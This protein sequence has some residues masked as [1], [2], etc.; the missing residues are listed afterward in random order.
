M[1]TELEDLARR[2]M[3]CKKWRWMGGMRLC[4]P[5][6]YDESAPWGMRIG[7][8]QG[9]VSNPKA[10]PDLSDPATVGCLLALVREAWP[11]DRAA[12]SPMQYMSRWFVDLPDNEGSEECSIVAS[13]EVE[14]LV[15]ALEKT[16]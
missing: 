1:A 12:V 11:C 8:G 4:M 6:M 15:L 10:Y 7:D 2:V 13:S 3:A 14:A 9:Y 5:P 16:P